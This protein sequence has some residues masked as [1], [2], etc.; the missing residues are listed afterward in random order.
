MIF[1]LHYDYCDI[2]LVLLCNSDTKK[3][4]NKQKTLNQNGKI[5]QYFDVHIEKGSVVN[6]NYSL[7]FS[8]EFINSVCI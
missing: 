4:K 3:Q 1:R 5:T 7:V 6:L 8:I 2:L